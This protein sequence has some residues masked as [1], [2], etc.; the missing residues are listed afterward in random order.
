MRFVV[1]ALWQLYRF[2]RGCRSRPSGKHRQ[3]LGWSEKSI[4][5]P[6]QSLH[7]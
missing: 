5:L 6:G 7:T 3:G 1:L 2:Q 4:T